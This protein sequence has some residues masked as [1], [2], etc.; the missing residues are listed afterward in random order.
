[1]QSLSAIPIFLFFSYNAARQCI[2]SLP[3]KAWYESKENVEAEIENVESVLIKSEDKP[4]KF[5]QQSF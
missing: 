2:Q 4:L 5:Q 3:W 1:M